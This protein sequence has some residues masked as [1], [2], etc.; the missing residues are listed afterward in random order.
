MNQS[1][2]VFSDFNPLL[3]AAE[4]VFP[5]GSNSVSKSC[6]FLLRFHHFLSSGSLDFRDSLFQT[7]TKWTPTTLSGTKYGCNRRLLTPDPNHVA[8]GLTPGLPCLCLLYCLRTE[9]WWPTR[10]KS[11]FVIDKIIET[12]SKCYHSFWIQGLRLKFVVISKKETNVC[13]EIDVSLPMAAG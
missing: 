6:A 12:E 9:N 13:T 11:S 7:L 1:F 10:G 3:F 4:I 2:S 8:H 5:H